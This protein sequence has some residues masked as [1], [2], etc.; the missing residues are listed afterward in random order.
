MK[1]E[2]RKIGGKKADKEKS[3]TQTKHKTNTQVQG[4]PQ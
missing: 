4:T 2:L 1:I 3:T